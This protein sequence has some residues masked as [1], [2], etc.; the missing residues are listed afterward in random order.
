MLPYTGEVLLSQFGQYNQAVWPALLAAYALGALAVALAVRPAPA[1]HRIIAAILAGFWL[2]T[3]VVWHLGW[4][5]GINFLAYAFGPVFVVQGLLLVWTGVVRDRVAFRFAPGPVGW[6]VLALIALA[7]LLPPFAARLAGAGWTSAALFGVAPG[8]VA[9]FTLA[10]L[11]LARPRAPLHL[12]VIPL[13]WALAA[14]AM[15]WVLR[16]P[17]DLVLALA[18]IAA[19]CLIPWKNRLQGEKT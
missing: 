12:T 5:A 1:G 17:G 3:G 6:V 19:G 8:P 9:A 11:L 4:F 15:S 14:A 2:W 16:L 13:L 7:V 10:M 18:G